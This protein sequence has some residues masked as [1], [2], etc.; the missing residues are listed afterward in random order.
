MEIVT[1]LLLGLSTLLFIGPVFFYLVQSSIEA[2]IRAGLSV[3]IGIILGD[4]IYVYIIL[5]GFATFFQD[6]QHQ[7][8]MAI[9]GAILLLGLGIKYIFKPTLKKE[10]DKKTISGSYWYYG[11]NGFLLN[12]V[13]PFVLAVW[14]GF[15]TINQSKFSDQNSVIIS[16]LTTLIIIFITDCIKAFFAQKFRNFMTAERFKTAYRIFG[17]VMLIFGIRLLLN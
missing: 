5:K 8:W 15:Y 17:I 11:L 13:N 10:F 6:P 4:L 3:A 7:R 2:G 16:L 9:L 12:F 1:G 14:I